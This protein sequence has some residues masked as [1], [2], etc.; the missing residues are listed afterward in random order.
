MVQEARE[1]F[2]SGKTRDVAFRKQNLRGLLRFYEENEAE[3]TQVLY[4]DLK[5]VGD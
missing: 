5:K 1:Q 4:E 2:N 3:L